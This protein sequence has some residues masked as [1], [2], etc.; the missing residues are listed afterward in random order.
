MILTSRDTS[1]TDQGSQ[2]PQTKFKT[3]YFLE[4]E[5]ERAQ[6]RVAEGVAGSPLSR[7]AYVGHDPKTLGI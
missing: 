4:R 1:S 5:S 7:K 3:I 6:E 2:V